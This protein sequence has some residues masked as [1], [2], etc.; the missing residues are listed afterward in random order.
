MER[1]RAVIVKEMPVPIPAVPRIVGHNHLG[2]VP[3]HVPV[4]DVPFPV[5]KGQNQH[6]EQPPVVMPRIRMAEL[7]EIR[8]NPVLFLLCIRL[9]HRL[10]AHGKADR[11][12]GAL[13][14][15]LKGLLPRLS[16]GKDFLNPVEIIRAARC[17]GEK[18]LPLIICRQGNPG[19][20]RVRLI[21]KQRG[22]NQK[23]SGKPLKFLRGQTPEWS[24]R[25]GIAHRV[26]MPRKK[27]GV[28]QCFYMLENAVQ[29]EM[30]GI[31]PV[32]FRH[33]RI[34]AGAVIRRLYRK[35][36]TFSPLSLHKNGSSRLS[37]Y[38]LSRLRR[39]KISSSRQSAGIRRGESCQGSA[40][41]S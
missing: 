6:I 3:H 15:V 25:L 14:R 19:C 26:F 34:R 31:D 23:A 16:L 4:N 8:R 13:R 7:G 11:Q 27:D 12:G 28:I 40:L 37:R 18:D 5:Q 10:R 33:P 38:S 21:C 1:P 29:K 20:L 22:G 17:H 36:H 9:P 35:F 24:L 30:A 2:M 32:F 41:S 39:D